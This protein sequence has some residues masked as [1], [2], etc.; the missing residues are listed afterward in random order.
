MKNYFNN[1]LI[2]INKLKH[3]FFNLLISPKIKKI[4]KIKIKNGK[5]GIL[6]IFKN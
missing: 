2:S 5:K 4:I 1:V 3:F 6:N